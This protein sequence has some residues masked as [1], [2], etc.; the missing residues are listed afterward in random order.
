MPR[1]ANAYRAGEQI[2]LNSGGHFEPGILTSN[3]RLEGRSVW[4]DVAL[5]SGRRE[6]TSVRNVHRPSAAF[7]AWQAAFA[8]QERSFRD[9]SEVCLR[10]GYTFGGAA[11]CETAQWRAY[12]AAREQVSTTGAAAL[13]V[14]PYWH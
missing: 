12:E 11:C 1:L 9:L 2:W 13:A 6:T 5:D 7:S 8:V 4:V 10:R 3:A 14:H